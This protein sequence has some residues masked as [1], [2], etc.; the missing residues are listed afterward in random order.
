MKKQIPY[1]VIC[2]S[3]VAENANHLVVLKTGKMANFTTF[4]DANFQKG[5][6]LKTQYYCSGTLVPPSFIQGMGDP[7]EENPNL[8][9]VDIEKAQ[10]ALDALL[11]FEPQ[12]DDDGNQ[13]NSVAKVISKDALVVVINQDIRAIIQQ[14][15]LERIPTK[16]EGA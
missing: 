4:K 15:G 7:L 1:S 14:A 8:E 16:E 2:G 9:G 13:T 6:L 5:T 12:F 11:I 3:E 10:S